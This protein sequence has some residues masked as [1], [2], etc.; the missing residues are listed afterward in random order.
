L[1]MSKPRRPRL[2]FSLS[3]LSATACSSCRTNL[4]MITALS[5]IQ[6]SR[7]YQDAVACTYDKAHEIEL[8]AMGF[9]ATMVSTFGDRN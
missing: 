8:R 9:H 5:V 1:T 7:M 6:V 4:G 2:R 3:L